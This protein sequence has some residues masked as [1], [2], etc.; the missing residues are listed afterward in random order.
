MQ[1]VVLRQYVTHVQD[2][3]PQSNESKAAAFIE[4]GEHAKKK[5]LR[6]SMLAQGITRSKVEDIREILTTIHSTVGLD[7]ICLTDTHGVGTPH[8]FAHLVKLVKSWVPVP[9]QVHC[10]DHLGLGVANACFAVSAGASVIH[11]TVHGMGHLAGLAALEEVAVALTV[12]YGID[13]NINY[14]GIFELSQTVERFTGIQMPPHKP[15]VGMRAFVN[16]NDAIYNQMNLER[17]RA[18]IPRINILPYVPEWVGNRERVFL[19]DGLTEEAIRWNLELL[20][21]PANDDQVKEIYA[22][23]KA[24]YQKMDRPASD[25]EFMEIALKIVSPASNSNLQASA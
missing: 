3:E 8:G 4:L 19:G 16:A 17:R 1:E 24:F 10:H 11:T 2:I 5:G 20:G 22:R 23:S 21:M 15:V 14:E 25:D 18:G 12:G 7:E 13:L 6:V 9:L